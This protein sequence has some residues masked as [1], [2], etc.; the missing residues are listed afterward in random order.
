MAHAH[1]DSRSTSHERFRLPKAFA[2]TGT[3]AGSGADHPVG[4]PPERKADRVIPGSVEC[5]VPPV[6]RAGTLRP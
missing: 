6:G 4:V 1:R 3:G 2:S 5:G